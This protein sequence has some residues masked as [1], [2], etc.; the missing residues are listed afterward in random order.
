MKEKKNITNSLLRWSVTLLMF[1]QTL[2]HSS[3]RKSENR[4]AI[5]VIFEISENL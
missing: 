5:Q 4:L 1:I 3:L 2:D